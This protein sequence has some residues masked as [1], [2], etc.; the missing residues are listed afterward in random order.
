MKQTRI[1][2]P[3]RIL[4]GLTLLL[5]AGFTALNV[6]AYRQAYTMTHYTVG[7]PRTETPEAL[8]PLTKYRVL[9][10]GVNLPRPLDER[11]P[12]TL[13]PHAHA[14]TIATPDG[15]TL[16]AWYAKAGDPAPLVI[17]FHGYSTEKTR[18]L[19]EARQIHAMG[20]SVLLVDF[21]G[22]GGSS[23][24]YT[25][26]GV[27][28]A[29]DVV[30]AFRYAQENLPFSSLVLYG[31]SMGSAAILRAIHTYTIHPNGVILESV[32]DR[33]RNTL[34]NRFDAMGLPSFPAAE[35]LAF[36]GGCQFG[37]SGFAHNPVDYAKALTCPAL[38]LHGE[39]DPRATLAE[40]R[41][42]FEADPDSRKQFVVFEN[43][44]H[45]SY[46]AQHPDQWQWAIQTF[47]A[48]FM[49]P[50]PLQE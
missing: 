31:Q 12:A 7:G 44:G 48:P 26:L 4:M 11:S 33:M 22:S 28:E 16:S 29:D 34:R 38:F 19:L 25:T 45:D 36:W 50:S 47:L 23:E 20:A 17:F 27:L 24:S 37:F 21:R 35:L 10:C 30:A 5:L 42:V 13:A 39:D 41:R 18:L 32:F 8:K 46:V 15:I 2:K 9:L 43:V 49:A 3:S 40:G 6:L 14:L 1:L